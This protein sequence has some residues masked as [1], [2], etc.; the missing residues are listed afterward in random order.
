MSAASRSTKPRGVRGA[1]EVVHAIR[2]RSDEPAP[3][4]IVSARMIVL[5][6]KATTPARDS[7][8]R[9]DGG[10]RVDVRGRAGAADD[11]RLIKKFAPGR[12]SSAWETSGRR[13]AP[14]AAGSPSRDIIFA[15]VMQR[16]HDVDE[17]PGAENR[18]R[19]TSAI[20]AALLNPVMSL[21]GAKLPDDRRHRGARRRRRAITSSTHGSR[22]RPRRARGTNQR[23]NAPPSSRQG[24]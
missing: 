11:E 16:E 2:R 9:I 22:P 3:M 19:P 21:T 4:L 6:K 8:R 13:A 20:C 14:I 17:R 7:V 5:K 1:D 10:S 15:G 23:L 18:R 12:A 24:I